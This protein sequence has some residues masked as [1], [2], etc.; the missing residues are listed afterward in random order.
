MGK[1]KIGLLFPRSSLY[2]G[3][4]F[5]VTEGFRAALQYFDANE[6][7]L[8]TDNVGIGGMGD[9]VYQKAEKMLLNDQV[10]ILVAY[11]DHFAAEKVEPLMAAANRILIAIDPGASVPISW[12]A[13][14]LTFHLTLDAAFGSRI[15]GH[16]AGTDGSTNGAFLTSFYD[17]G[18]L[19]CSAMING[20]NEQGGTVVYNYV[21]PFRFE[22]FDIAPLQAA[23]E[24]LQPN[25]VLAQLSMDMGTLFL[26]EYAAAGLAAKARFF[27]SPFLLEEVFLDTLAFPFEGI[28]GCVPWARQLDNE[29]NSAFTKTIT[30]DHGRQPNCF[31][32]L[33]WDA[34]RFAMMV[35][36]A[37]RANNN[38]GKKAAAALKGAIFEGTRGPM[39]LDDHTNYFTTPL[40]HAAIVPKEDGQSQLQL[41]SP[42]ADVAAQWQAFTTQ[43]TIG[44]FSRWTN[45][46]LCTT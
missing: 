39:Q 15:T 18:Y 12:A 19:S 30:E 36:E 29:M 26:K 27:A 46:Y 1:L 20:Y 17:G 8:I 22:E 38:N 3:I 31:A 41:G 13:A 28:T 2:P 35:A 45:T 9:D 6:I 34:A 24:A 14:P 10:D 44:V 5:D 16:M 25:V 43:P 23:M 33:A 42:V 37:L 4:G 11:I 7:T 32:A 21:A 40:Y